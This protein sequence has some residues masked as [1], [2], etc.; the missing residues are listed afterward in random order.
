MKQY[1]VVIVGGGPAGL[2]AAINLFQQGY[3]NLLLVER[4]P[5]L[6][7]VLNQ[8]IHTGFGVEYYQQELS[9]PEY[10]SR[11]RQQFLD[12]G[13]AHETSTM[14]IDLS[15]ERVLTLASSGGIR[16]V[17]A[18]AVL[19][20]TGCRERTREAIEVAGSRPAGVFT[21]GQA[22]N[23]INLKH[24][25]IGRRVVIQ[26]SG[27]IGLIMARRLTLEGYEV[28]AVLERLPF[29]SGLIRNKSQCLDDFDIP[30]EFSTQIVSIEGKKRVEGVKTVR[31]DGEFRPVPGSE[32]QI[33]CD[34]VV[35]SVGL[36]PEVE[37]GKKAG[38]A[39]DGTTARVNSR[40][41]TSVPGIF[42]A[43]NSLHIHDL[44]DGASTEGEEAAQAVGALLKDP[45]G[46]RTG[47]TSVLPY[48]PM[49][50]ETRYDEAFFRSLNDGQ[51]VCI[52]CPKGCLVSA[53]DSGCKRGRDFYQRE[54]TSRGRILTTT[55]VAEY[56]GR[57]QT[58]AVRSREPLPFSELDT[59]HRRLLKLDRIEQLEFG[60]EFPQGKIEFSAVPDLV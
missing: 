14:V 3:R 43:G 26:G 12:L 15:P 23:L 25:K 37:L 35:F 1:D 57:R 47:V 27:D 9:G 48:E 28:V 17:Q 46:F 4:N 38:V 5:S 44:A 58:L 11:L 30:L 40:F 42:V 49:A 29:L 33:A 10:A 19:L 60:L 32:R 51:K 45:A 22:Q 31:L 6:G 56:Q 36:I 39:F 16:R 2:A 13:I 21:A 50:A 20:T 53:E 59:V 55:V 8:C 7:G 54:Q 18:R 52:V 41:E 34:T 24:L